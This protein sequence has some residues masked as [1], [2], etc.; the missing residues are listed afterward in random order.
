VERAG[1]EFVALLLLEQHLVDLVL[2]EEVLVL[3]LADLLRQL[4]VVLLVALL[5]QLH[6]I[7]VLLLEDLVSFA[8]VVLGHL[9][10]SLKFLIPR[11]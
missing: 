3:K 1:Q 5:Q 6:L 2:V 8:Y 9:L 11:I 7:L 10:G 4:E